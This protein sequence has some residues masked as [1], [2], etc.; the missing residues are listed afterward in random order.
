MLGLTYNLDVSRSERRKL[1]IIYLTNLM[2]KAISL[3]VSTI[4][5]LKKEKISI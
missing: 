3:W 5:A 1:R 4:P 2:K